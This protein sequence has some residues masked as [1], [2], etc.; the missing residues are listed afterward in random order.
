[1]LYDL[2]SDIQKQEF[3]EK[4][5]ALYQKKCVVELTEKKPP[6]SLRQN[7]YLHLILCD[8]ALFYGCSLA[9]AK[10]HFF[11][12]VLN[13]ELFVRS[14]TS[15]TGEE[16]TDCRSSAELTT[17]EMAL[18]ITRFRD[19]AANNGH[20]IPSGDEHGYQVYMAREIEKNKEWL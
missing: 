9:Y 16:F 17:D 13:S 4:A 12:C 6:R 18:A 20:Y 1:M 10:Q 14:K 3:K 19:W 11:K 15:K 5:N 2:T 7:N 8:W